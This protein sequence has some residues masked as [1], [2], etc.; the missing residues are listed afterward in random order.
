MKN[1]E[2]TA[3]CK[4]EILN[5]PL[6]CLLNLCVDGVARLGFVGQR[7]GWVRVRI[8]ELSSTS[9]QSSGQII[10]ITSHMYKPTLLDSN[11]NARTA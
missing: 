8:L 3:N 7:R 9:S 5:G 6:Y 2:T 1:Y 10:I 4:P 11:I